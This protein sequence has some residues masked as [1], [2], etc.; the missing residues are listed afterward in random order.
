MRKL[1]R[2][3]EIY[4]RCSI[5]KYKTDEV[6]LDVIKAILYAGTRAP[7]GKN[8]QPWRFIVVGGKEKESMLAAMQKGIDREKDGV[9][10]LP[11]TRYGL[12]DAQNTL[13]IM[14]QA[15]VIIMI[16]NQG[17]G[18][19]FDEISGEERVFEIVNTQSIGAAI[20]NMCLAAEN[21]G[22]GTLWIANTVFA[23]TELCDWLDTDKQLVAALA[24]GYPDEKPGKRPRK[25]LDDVVTY[26][27]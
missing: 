19:P 10:M 26:R 25:I 6:P 4:S 17:S 13:N 15:P 16:L 5:R 18:S 14:K 11:T 1:M 2:I 24:V 9:S 3:E 27:M 21:L 8:R 23:Y 22:L 7:S 20:Q 12:P